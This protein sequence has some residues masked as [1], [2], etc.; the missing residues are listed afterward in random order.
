MTDFSAILCPVDFSDFSRHA[1]A[2]AVQI[3]RWFG[4]RLTLL[5]VYPPAVAPPP[6]AFGGLP[7]PVPVPAFPPVTESPEHAHEEMLAMLTTFSGTLEAAGVAV[8]LHAR[9]GSPVSMI[10]NEARDLPADLLVLGTHGHSGFD[11]FIL[12]SVTEKMVRKAPC[13]VIAVPPPVTDAPR[14]PLQLFKRILCAVDFSDASRRGLEYALALAKE[15]DAELLLMHVIEG[16]PDAPH[17]QQP[18]APATVEYLRLSEEEA[19]RRLR[20][21]LPEDAREWCRPQTILA[22]GRPYVELLRAARERDAH[23]IVMGVH[24]RNPIDLAFFGSTT[25]HVIRSAPCAVLTLRG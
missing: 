17:W 4:A 23:L 14:D 12:G 21:A 1:A 20:E 16:L 9:A 8:A 2:H 22:T 3:A 24:G 25:N 19:L 13:P 11:R 10:L 18:P 5:Y 15:A 6:V 7:G